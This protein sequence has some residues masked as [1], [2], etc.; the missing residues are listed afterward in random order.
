MFAIFQESIEQREAQPTAIDKLL[1]PR[2]TNQVSSKIFTYMKKE[3]I[4]LLLN[5]Q[6]NIKSDGRAKH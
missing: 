6:N 2:T 4:L 1:V 3:L 5:I